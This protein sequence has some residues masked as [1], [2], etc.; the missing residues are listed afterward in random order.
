[1]GAKGSARFMAPEQVLQDPITTAADIYSFGA[2]L[3]RMLAGSYVFGGSPV[4]VLQQHLKHMPQP[5]R[6]RNPDAGC[7]EELEDLIMVCLRKAPEERPSSADALLSRMERML[8]LFAEQGSLS[9]LSTPPPSMPE[10]DGDQLPSWLESASGI[11][12][13][14]ESMNR[15]EHESVSLSPEQM[16]QPAFGDDPFLDPPDQI[17]LLPTT[18]DPTDIELAHRQRESGL[19]HRRPSR[20]LNRLKC[21]RPCAP[22]RCLSLNLSRR[23]KRKEPMQVPHWPKM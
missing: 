6:Q 11:R 17:D 8:N 5:L 22:I 2:T 23:W 14:N 10:D 20:K 7:P 18:E 13:L 12:S 16:T 3:Y 9:R 1:M 15:V 19:M 4:E 21:L